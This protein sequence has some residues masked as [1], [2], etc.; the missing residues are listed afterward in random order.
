MVTE[1]EHSKSNNTIEIEVNKIFGTKNKILPEIVKYLKSKYNNIELIEEI[2]KN[3]LAR[4][5]IVMKRGKKFAQLIRDKYGNNKYPFHIIL[6]KAKL[7]KHKYKLTDN[8]FHEFQKIYET[9]LVGI[10]STDVLIPDN[11]MIK[12]FGTYTVASTGF[13]NNLN[14]TDNK[15]LQEILKLHALNK[16]LHSNI[17][18]QSLQYTSCN[19]L[20]LTGNYN[21]A[22][23]IVYN[24]IHPVIAALF[25]PKINILEAVFIRSNISRMVKNRYNNEPLFKTDHLLYYYLLNDNN[26]IV[27]DNRSP[28]LD[29]L[30]RCHIQY[31]LWNNILHLRSGKYYNNTMQN[32][33]VAI[34]NCKQNKY[35]TPD[36]I[37]GKHEGAILKRLFNAFSFRP[38]VV[39]KI[40]D[41]NRNPYQQTNVPVL[42]RI[43]MINLVN[44]DVINNNTPIDIKNS[45]QSKQAIIS[46]NKLGEQIQAVTH[47]DGILVFYLDRRSPFIKLK[48]LKPELDIIK[49]PIAISGLPQVNTNVIIDMIEDQFDL[50]GDPYKLQSV[51][52]VETT[53]N[54]DLQNAKII[55]N[56]TYIRMWNDDFRRDYIK[57][58][59]NAVTQIDFNNP[60]DI[61]NPID[62]VLDHND[63]IDSF[64]NRG[65]IFIYKLDNPNDNSYDLM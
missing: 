15:Y 29:L 17:F 42:D 11:N 53:D 44:S 63:V 64:M 14:E 25:I 48:Q 26:D 16:G 28:M 33:L 39:T 6:E 1:H 30:N 34:D 8:E 32:L 3:F 12:I 55:G 46:N 36:I 22:K 38:I 20:G 49:G 5:K 31:N 47:T 19:L 7:I 10:Q 2:Q 37:Y 54:D 41:I 50:H 59:P 27:C 4:Y 21:I 61:I 60:T 57:Y 56:S 45:L 40:V 24:S 43:H 9:E 58:D 65:T 35:D 13:I 51:V 23:D 52:V 18:L 62:P